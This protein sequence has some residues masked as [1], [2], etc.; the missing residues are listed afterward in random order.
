MNDDRPAVLPDE[1]ARIGRF[2][3]VGLFNTL[4]GYGFIMIA[5][6]LGAGDYGANVI[7]FA[8]GMPIAYFL[9][10]GITFRANGRSNLPEAAKY[11]AAFIIAYAVNITVVFIGRALG[12]VEHPAVQLLAICTYAAAFYVLTRLIVF[13][14]GGQEPFPRN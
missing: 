8:L 9:H 7:G 14:S 3:L 10:R 4:L 13:P 5:L 11:A 2:V 6:H 12:F 1:L